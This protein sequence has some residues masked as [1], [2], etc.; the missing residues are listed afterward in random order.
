ML[1]RKMDFGTQG[2]DVF[3][4][5]VHDLSLQNL[6]TSVIWYDISGPVQLMFSILQD[7]YKL[8]PCMDIALFAVEVWISEK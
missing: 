4:W 8:I 5:Y 3:I 2:V 6:C 1:L 7:I